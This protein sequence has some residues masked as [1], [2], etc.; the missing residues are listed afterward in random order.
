MIRQ[1]IPSNEPFTA[2]R[3]EHLLPV[4]VSPVRQHVLSQRPF[5]L[6]PFLTRV[7]FERPSVRR[8]HELL[9]RVHRF[10]ALQMQ[11][12]TEHLGARR[13][14]KRALSARSAR[15]HLDPA[16]A[17]VDVPVQMLLQVSLQVEESREVGVAVGALEARVALQVVLLV[18]P[19]AAALG[20]PL[21][22]DAALERALLGRVRLLLHLLRVPLLVAVQVRRRHERLAAQH[23]LVGPLARVDSHVRDEVRLRR[24][25]LRAHATRE[26]LLPGVR[27]TVRRQVRLRDAPGAADFTRDR[28]VGAVRPLVVRQTARV[29]EATPADV[30]RVRPLA[31]VDALVLDEQ[32]PLG[33][34]FRAVVALEDEPVLAVTASVA[35]HRALA[36]ELLAADGAR[37]RRGVEVAPGVRQVVA[38]VREPLAARL[39]RVRLLARVH[40]AVQLQAALPLELLAAHEALVEDARVH[41]RVVVKVALL[42]ERLLADAAREHVGCRARPGRVRRRRRRRARGR[43]QLHP[44]RRR[45]PLLSVVARQRH[46][47]RLLGV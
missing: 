3:T 34:L 16:R 14:L 46:V 21:A 40:A 37:E 45:Q 29:D 4:R 18:L 8:V 12:A 17:L 22:A 47:H 33:E 11:N 20:E 30:T 1:V 28:P 5:A 32:V 19:H 41:A 26:R 15:L 13:T 35:D 36:A 2:E 10:V 9:P 6:K 27:A 7:A 43:L 38:G 39:A 24:E 42:L 25:A 23:A 44:R 31:R